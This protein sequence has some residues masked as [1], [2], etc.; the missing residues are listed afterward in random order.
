[1]VNN[2]A[3]SFIN[4]H[5]NLVKHIEIAIKA[6]YYEV[7]LLVQA[8]FNCFLDLHK[9]FTKHQFFTSLIYRG[10]HIPASKAASYV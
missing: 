8:F 9:L 6:N 5:E 3:V 1:M 4:I 2:A 7:K 10:N